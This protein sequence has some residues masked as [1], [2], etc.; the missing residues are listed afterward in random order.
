MK[1]A[2]FSCFVKEKYLRALERN[3]GKHVERMEEQLLRETM[4]NIWITERVRRLLTES[5]DRDDGYRH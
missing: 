3:T 4:R 1:S 2:G 5:D